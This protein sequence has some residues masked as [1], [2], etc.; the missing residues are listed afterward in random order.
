MRPVFAT[1]I[2]LSL[3]VFAAA[4]GA[5]ADLSNYGVRIEPDKRVIVVLAALE[6]GRIA[7]QSGAAER[8][9][10]VP[11]SEKGNAFREQLDRDTAQMPE[12]LRMRI[13]QFVAKYKKRHQAAEDAKLIA[14]FI[15]MAYSLSPAPDLADPVVVTDLPGELLDVLDFAP[16]ARE[17][18]RRSGI[19]AK[20][21]E[22]VKL[23]QTEA[24]GRLRSST[25]EMV[26][27]YLEYLN[28]RPQIFYRETRKVEVQK[29]KSKSTVLQK[30]ETIERERRFCIVPEM[31]VP[32]G[33]INFLNIRDDYYLVVP[34]DKD[35]SASDARRA[36]IQF[37]VDPLI[38][39]NSK[40]V[41]AVKDG[42][43]SLLDER[44]KA[45]PSISPDMFLAV[46]RSLVAAVEAR[47]LE[48]TKTNIAVNQAREK[49]ARAAGDAER[50][51]ITAEL[52]RYK[53]SL[54]D[55]S[56]VMLSEAYERGAVMAF[57]FADQLKGMEDS[58]FD[59]A[60]SM[61]E[62]IAGFDA[63]KESDR[64]AKYAE[65][66]Q[67]GLAARA[68]RG[69]S[70]TTSIV[71]N[72]V[73][74]KLIEIQATIER[75]EFGRATEALKKLLED[76]PQEPRI[77]YNLGRI[78]SMEAEATNDPNVE[79][80]KLLDAKAWYGNVIRTRSAATDPALISLTFVAL[81]RI[82]E[83]FDDNAYALKL[84]EEAIKVGDAA[85]GGYRDALAAKQRL[86]KKEQ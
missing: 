32:T 68:E 13:G 10:S 69:R 59:I 82:Y 28:T 22:Y 72:P 18:F 45:D 14:P 16:L 35:V 66:R 24:D 30:T 64:L 15:A 50:R 41:T 33:T 11:L 78:A 75:R 40:D 81:G 4:Q 46:S 47:E 56:A 61:R 54:T 65:A 27:D 36:F 29:G 58:G 70:V 20:L 17:Y 1:I 74:N 6:A 77:Y 73:T 53:R 55:E 83:Y 49:L 44:R 38:L 80:Q 60:S 3:A 51:Q 12:E 37:V 48:F 85:G 42:I 67:R 31:L 25:R 52:D 84:Y 57:Y 23:Y 39:S 62:M 76:N 71:E 7:G 34:P 19:S 9:I 86:V 43:K 5:V 2:L 79:S 8:A 26:N 63:S 21:D